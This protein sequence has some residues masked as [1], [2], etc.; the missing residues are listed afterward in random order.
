MLFLKVKKGRSKN[1]GR[2]CR[3]IAEKQKRAD[4]N[5]LFFVIYFKLSQDSLKPMIQRMG[6]YT[7]FL[8]DLSP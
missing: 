4:E 5:G 7:L 2:V 3:E 8:F 1:E 6:R